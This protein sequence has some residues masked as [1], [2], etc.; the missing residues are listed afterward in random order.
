VF[1]KIL[2]R[3]L[4]FSCLIKIFALICVCNLPKAY[5]KFGEKRLYITNMAIPA[6]MAALRAH[7]EGTSI[8]KAILQ[9]VFGGYIMQ[10]SLKRAAKIEEKS[11]WYAWET[12]LMFN[13]GASLCESAGKDKF[14]FRM[15]IGPVWLISEDKDVKFKLGIN[16]VIAPLFH[17][18]EGSSFDYKQSLKYGTLVFDRKSKQ[19]GNLYGSNALAYSTANTFVTNY[20]GNHSGHELIHTYQYRRN[21]LYPIQIGDYWPE[22]T[23]KYFKEDKWV[24]D[25]GWFLNWSMQSAWASWRDKNR[26]YDIPLEQEAYY[27]EKYRR[28]WTP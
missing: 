15:D 18:S 20:N 1:K 13:L 2:K 11:A 23:E 5:A 3:I 4:I 8:K 12:K 16:G 26:D 28:Q 25:T 10:E 24:D 17:L 27:M 21:C 6:G 14:T 7:F 9:A 19:N 22:F